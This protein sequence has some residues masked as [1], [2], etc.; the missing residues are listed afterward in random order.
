MKLMRV[1][2]KNKD[3]IL[4][5]LFV[6]FILLFA[7]YTFKSGLMGDDSL[8]NKNL[9]NYEPIKNFNDMIAATNYYYFNWNGRYVINFLNHAIVCNGMKVQTIMV[10]LG[11]LCCFMSIYKLFNL[12]MNFISF[13][14]ILFGI[15]FFSTDRFLYNTSCLNISLNYVIIAPVYIIL[16]KYLILNKSNY[17]VREYSLL[18][19]V[20]FLCGMLSETYSFSLAILIIVFIISKQFSLNKYHIGLGVFYIAGAL[21]LLLSPG[22]ALRGNIIRSENYYILYWLNGIISAF[23]NW[24]FIALL[25]VITCMHLFNIKYKTMNHKDKTILLYALIQMVFMIFSPYWPARACFLSNMLLFSLCIK[26]CI[27]NNKFLN[28]NIN[29]YSIAF[30][31]AICGNIG[32]NIG[33]ILVG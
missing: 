16:L 23:T 7:L 13:F 32:I 33:R 3:K 12:K 14:G 25:S 27:E 29:I 4:A 26:W 1:I 20:S 21:I 10:T 24:A 28:E 30:Y 2:Q 31:I 15:M 22:S 19:I 9:A 18:C 11:L 6:C 5:F 8:Y 17:K